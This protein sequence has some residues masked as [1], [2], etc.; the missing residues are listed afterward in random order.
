M[1][2]GRTRPIYQK[3]ASQEQRYKNKIRKAEKRY[4][5]CPKILEYVKSKIVKNRKNYHSK[6]K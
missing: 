6:E 5:N 1:S 3:Y 2:K 4:K